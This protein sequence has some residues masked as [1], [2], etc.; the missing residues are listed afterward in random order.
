MFHLYVP[1]D[2]VGMLRRLL[3]QIPDD[4]YIKVDG[5]KAMFYG[6]PNTWTVYLDS[7]IEESDDPFQ[8]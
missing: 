7:N 5:K 3:E 6:D 2:N 8:F 1:C 4:A